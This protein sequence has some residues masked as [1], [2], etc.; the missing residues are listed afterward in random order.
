MLSIIIPSRHC[1]TR[2]ASRSNLLIIF[3]FILLSSCTEGDFLNYNLT[4][5]E[6][7]LCLSGYI[8]PD[9]TYVVLSLS[10]S[11]NDY[12]ENHASPTPNSLYEA[13]VILFEDNIPFDTLINKCRIIN[14]CVPYIENYY[15]SR[16][17]AIEGRN[18]SIKAKYK[19]FD[20]VIATTYIPL[21]VQIISHDIEIFEFGQ[22]YYQMKEKIT[23]NLFSQ[24]QS[25]GYRYYLIELGYE[26]IN[27]NCLNY[28][29]YFRLEPNVI[30]ENYAGIA[31]SQVGESV[32]FSNKLFHTNLFSFQFYHIVYE[33]EPELEGTT[34]FSLYSISE[35]YYRYELSRHIKLNSLGDA[36]SNPVTIYSNV[37]GGYGIF[38]GFSESK[39]TVE[40]GGK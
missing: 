30:F 1:E 20:E 18:Y 17:E 24:D 29:S 2:T 39:Y 26:I 6:T 19:E 5:P 12:V 23:I 27:S 31:D 14:D 40:F 21:P 15:V 22:E 16:K 7:K 9:S 13:T 8:C 33:N 38:M 28:N 4:E 11:Y 25:Q 34:T 10:R 3:Y 36:N 35:D 32:F 37:E